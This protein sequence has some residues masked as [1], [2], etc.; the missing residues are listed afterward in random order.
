MSFLSYTIDSSQT[1]IYIWVIDPESSEP[2]AYKI[3]YTKEDE[4]E[5]AEAKAKGEDGVATDL[6]VDFE[7]KE[8]SNSQEP[9]VRTENIPQDGGEK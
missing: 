9:A 4:K 3:P 1:W 6:S 2:R 8:T 5:L 7:S